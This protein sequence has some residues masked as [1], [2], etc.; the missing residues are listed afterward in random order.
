M[1]FSTGF[2][3]ELSN[4]ESSVDF[5]S[6]AE[7]GDTVPSGTSSLISF[8]DLSIFWLSVVD[9]MVC[10]CSAVATAAAAFLS[11]SLSLS[12]LLVLPPPR[13]RRY[14]LVF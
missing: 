2:H 14:T 12:P 8:N 5:V 13:L 4:F 7:W 1:S 6:S 11:S 10:S 3:F 9:E